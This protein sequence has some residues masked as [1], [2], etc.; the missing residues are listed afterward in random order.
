[1]AKILGVANEDNVDSA[2]VAA[3]AEEAWKALR[4]CKN[5]SPDAALEYLYANFK[6]FAE[7]YP[8]VVQ[9]MAQRVYTRRVFVR[10]LAWVE[11]HPAKTEVEFLE[12]QAKYVQML[13]KN[14]NPRSSGTERAQVYAAALE[15]L[16]GERDAFKESVAAA[17]AAY[18]EK[19]SLL[20]Q[21]NA[22]EL[23]RLFEKD[24]LAAAG[25][26]RVIADI[27]TT[28]APTSTYTLPEAAELEFVEL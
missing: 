6:K 21:K 18:E 9:Y 7:G 22:E 8:I 23:Q 19:T 26:I 25:T 5:L 13:Y 2:F 3:K 27:P 24:D 15:K 1:M 20:M 17:E 4:A 11:K 16:I 28:Y 14:Q 10:Y 12:S